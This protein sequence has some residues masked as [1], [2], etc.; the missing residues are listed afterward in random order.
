MICSSC[1]YRPNSADSVQ[2]CSLPKCQ[3]VYGK[4]PQV[5]KTRRNLIEIFFVDRGVTFED[6]AE[7][8]NTLIGA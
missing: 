4:T 6:H 8:I 2:F 3:Y 1:K 7:I 5:S